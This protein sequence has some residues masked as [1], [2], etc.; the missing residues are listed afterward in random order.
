[1]QPTKICWGKNN[2]SVAIRI[3]DSKPKRL[4]HRVAGA[5]ATPEKVCAAI[6]NA[7]QYGIENKVD[8][9]ELVYGNAWDG[10]Y[11]YPLIIG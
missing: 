1:M 5:D 4:E 7:A 9:G 2:R 11:K 6:V 3:P 10:K 8:P